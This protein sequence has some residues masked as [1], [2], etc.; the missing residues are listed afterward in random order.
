MSRTLLVGSDGRSSADGAVRLARALSHH[1]DA[2]CEVI[3]T[4]APLEFS[5]LSP[6]A[7]IP[8]GYDVIEENHARDL[9]LAI[10]A[11]IE[12]LPGDGQVGRV[13]TAVGSPVVRIVEH[14]AAM[15]ASL[16]LLGMEPPILAHAW[17]RGAT[18]LEL[19]RVS[20]V[21][22]LLVPE[23]GGELPSKAL[24]AIDFGALSIAAA[25]SAAELMR[26]GGHLYLCHVTWPPEETSPLPSLADWKNAYDRHAEARLQ[27][28]G[29]E[30]SAEF[31]V[32]A[33][34][35][36]LNGDP[37]TEVV[38]V[39]DR[40][41]VDVVA[42]GTRGICLLDPRLVGSVAATLVRRARWA[43]LLTPA[44]SIVDPTEPGGAG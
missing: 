16:I 6:P 21:P 33:H 23:E 14:A 25:R 36:L 27:A 39:A 1:L 4:L 32:K 9:E 26:P 37:A 8:A 40:L 38:A 31:T 5:A 29:E 11:Q 44:A 35:L 34:P 24:V 12:R 41:D 10:I 20:P 42:A 18:A 19:L 15:R 17:R 2:E 43:V 7:A 30:L 22:V 28:L 13:A 3:G